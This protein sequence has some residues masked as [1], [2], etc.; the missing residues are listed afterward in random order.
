VSKKTLSRSTGK[1][2]KN[3]K[4]ETYYD[5][6]LMAHEKIDTL[7]SAYKANSLSM[8]TGGIIKILRNLDDPLTLPL[9]SRQLIE[10][11]AWFVYNESVMVTLFYNY[12]H[13]VDTLFV[14]DVG[15]KVILNPTSI[16]SF[17]S[18]LCLPPVSLAT[19]VMQ[20]VGEKIE[21]DMQ[22]NNFLSFQKEIVKQAKIFVSYLLS[23]TKRGDLSKIDSLVN[24]Y[25][26]C[27]SLTHPTS[28]GLIFS[29]PVSTKEKT[30]LSATYL[31]SSL[32]AIKNV[33]ENMYLLL[34]YAE[35]PDGVRRV[36]Y[37]FS[38]LNKSLSK[39]A[40]RMLDYKVDYSYDV[41]KEMFERKVLLSN[42]L[43]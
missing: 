14:S 40:V 3:K 10:Y 20:K 29:S 26:L 4:E 19:Y 32:D 28:L 13:E 11:W 22:K 37:N 21:Y 6:A 9:I 27:C 5:K 24:E 12:K 41:M 38:F 15:R 33:S 16:E 8:I 25:R 23:Y 36:L 42:A 35:R 39:Y 34:N 7:I 17:V 43:E 1:I 2:L 30:I 31:V 18:S